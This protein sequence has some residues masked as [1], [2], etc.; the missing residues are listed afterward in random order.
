MPPDLLELEKR[1]VGRNTE[2]AEKIKVRLENAVAEIE[3]GKEEGN[4]D[5]VIVNHDLNDTF[6][7][8]VSTL[9]KWYPELDLYLK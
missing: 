4:F 3:Y 1:L 7:E 5:A 9:Q 6:A 2:T 8:L